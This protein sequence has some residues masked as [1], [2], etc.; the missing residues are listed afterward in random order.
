MD[1]NERLQLAR[2]ADALLQNH[3]WQ[4]AVARRRQALKDMWE[5]TPP[6]ELA[7]RE[8]LF[9]ELRALA[10]VEGSLRSILMDGQAIEHRAQLRR[11]RTHG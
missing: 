8:R 11:V 10:G 1:D 5:A 2:Q 7:E 6:A 3:A 9:T 4:A